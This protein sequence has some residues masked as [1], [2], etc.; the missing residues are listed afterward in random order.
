MVP[1]FRP[2]IEWLVRRRDETIAAWIKK[3]PR[4]NVYEDRALEVTSEMTIDVERQIA[5]V[6]QALEH[7]R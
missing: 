4:A 3:K 7:A 2:Q 1:L 6:E 5:A